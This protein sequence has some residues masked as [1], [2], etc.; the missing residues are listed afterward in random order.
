MRIL[1]IPVGDKKKLDKYRQEWSNYENGI[2]YNNKLIKELLTSSKWT[3]IFVYF[4]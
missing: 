2:K 3:P 1:E 4:L